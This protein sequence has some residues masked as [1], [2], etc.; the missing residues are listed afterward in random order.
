MEAEE[1][2]KIIRQIIPEEVVDRLYL[3]FIEAE[4]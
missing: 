2:E 3:M 4:L 1:A